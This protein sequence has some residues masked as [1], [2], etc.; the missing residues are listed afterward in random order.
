MAKFDIAYQRTIV[1]EGGYVNDPADKGGET[2]MGI[3]RKAHPKSSIWP[4]IDKVDKRGKTNRQITDILKRNTQLTH[5]IKVLYK[6]TYWDTFSLD[7]CKMQKFANEL[8]DD[9]VN[10]G[11]GSAAYVANIVFGLPPVRK[12]TKELLTKIKTYGR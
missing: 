11:I 10:R 2:Y 3:S 5:K 9:A 8:F 6:T 1:A 7:D 12:V 4:I